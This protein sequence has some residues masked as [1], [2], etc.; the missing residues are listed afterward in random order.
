MRFWLF[1]ENCVLFVYSNIFIRAQNIEKAMFH[2]VGDLF[3]IYPAKLLIIRITL[4]VL[5][6]MCRAELRRS[7]ASLKSE[8]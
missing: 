2:E 3:N 1:L 4:A 8:K 7:L 5:F 6:F